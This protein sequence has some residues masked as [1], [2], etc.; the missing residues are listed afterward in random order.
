MSSEDRVRGGADRQLPMAFTEHRGPVGRGGRTGTNP[1][2]RAGLAVAL[3]GLVVVA[4]FGLRGLLAVFLAVAVGVVASWILG[5]SPLP[6]GLRR[7]ASRQRGSA[8]TWG[9]DRPLPDVAELG[10]AVPGWL[11]AAVPAVLVAGLV[12]WLLGPLALVAVVVLAGLGFAGYRLVGTL[13]AP[14][15]P[16]LSERLR[17]EE[18]RDRLPGTGEAG[19]EVPRWLVAAVPAVLIAGL[20]AWLLGPLALVAVVVLAGLGFAG[21][22]LVGT[23]AAPDQPP[24]SERLRREEVR[25]RLPGTGEA[26]QEVPRWLVVAAAALL[27]T[28]LVTWLLGP[29][30]L[31]AVVVLAGLGFAGHR[32]VRILAAPDQPPLSERLRRE[33]VRDR[34]PGTGEAGQEVPRW[35]VAAVP[36]V[37]LTGLVTWLLGPLA[38]VA[39][40]VLAGL[41]FAGYR[42]VRILDVPVGADRGRPDR[43]GLWLRLGEEL[44]W[45]R[46]RAGPSEAG[47]R[48]L[49]WPL[50]LGSRSSL[51]G[52]GHDGPDAPERV[53]GVGTPELP[54]ER[55]WARHWSRLIEGARSQ[56]AEPVPDPAWNRTPRPSRQQDGTPASGAVDGAEVAEHHPAEA[57]SAPA[58]TPGTLTQRLDHQNRPGPVPATG[59][60]DHGEATKLHHPPTPAVQAWTPR[61]HTRPVHHQ[62]NTAPVPAAGEG[63]ATRPGPDP[64][65]TPTAEVAPASTPWQ[66][67]GPPQRAGQAAPWTSGPSARVTSPTWPAAWSNCPAGWWWRRPHC[68]SPAW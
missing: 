68:S 16:P 21:Y 17:R 27:L 42:L 44:P 43:R 48:L 18:V 63:P 15:Q 30:A 24:L 41:G 34:L 57:V 6:S 22:R 46:N 23:L 51:V 7:D 40:V 1:A 39:V 37:L 47:R 35:L 62:G 64:N 29:L 67:G 36:A 4:V 28:G 5:M 26:G 58:W 55:S 38:L 20:V 12:A 25:D 65:P 11:V 60:G 8:G 49:S 10:R 31:V 61:A 33:E 3:S 9:R 13:A 14:D 50:T 2:A 53:H 59:G 52:P 45:R 32:L 56:R 19:Q 66:W 54:E